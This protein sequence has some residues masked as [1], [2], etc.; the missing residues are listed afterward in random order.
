VI[1][2]DISATML[3]HARRNPEPMLIEP[4]HAEEMLQRL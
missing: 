1:A 2:G 4:I 3:D